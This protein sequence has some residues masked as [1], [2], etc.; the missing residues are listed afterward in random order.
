MRTPP[1]VVEP[2]MT[3][4]RFEPSARICSSTRA[5]APAPTAIIT[6]TAPT[7]MT[8]PS[9]VS[10]LRSLLTAS[11]RRAMRSSERARSFMRR[12]GLRCA[13]PGRRWPS[14]KREDAAREAR[15]VGLVRH[16]H[17][18]HALAV[19][20]LEQRHDLEAGARVERAGR[21]VGEDQQR[22]GDQRAR[23][24]HAL[25]LAARELRRVVV[26]AVGQPDALRASL[27][28]LL[29][30]L[31]LGHARIE[32]R[33][34]DV[35]DRRRAREQV[36]LLEHEAD[37]AVAHR[38]ELVAGELGDAFVRRAGTRRWSAGRGSRARS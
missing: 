15:H 24:R 21:L 11:A 33:Q 30:P 28:R 4:S 13:R 1:A 34:L 35:L 32:Q 2:G 37:V 3:S 12:P 6:I 5:C 22:L 14:R 16:Q 25:L 38:G 8:M 23:D 17:H 10:A 26:R 9:M 29:E 7:P 27:M 36:E 31:L 20:L 19:Q 18:R